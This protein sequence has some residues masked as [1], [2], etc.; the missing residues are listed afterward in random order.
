MQSVSHLELYA[1]VCYR[2]TLAQA[3]AHNTV[4][5]GSHATVA[6]V[7]R[8][9]AVIYCDVRAGLLKPIRADPSDP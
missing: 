1:D 8:A 4:A 5:L 9:E 2:C 3:Q 6:V 7:N